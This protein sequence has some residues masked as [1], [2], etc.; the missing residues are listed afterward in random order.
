MA[1]FKLLIES[2]LHIKDVQKAVKSENLVLRKYFENILKLTYHNK[3]PFVIMSANGLRTDA[4]SL[5]LKYKDL[6]YDNIHIISNGFVWDKNGVAVDVKKPIVHS[7]NKE[8]FK[9]EQI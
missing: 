9:Q 1:H 3:V 7:F 8:E 5:Y 6:L 2:G 4:I